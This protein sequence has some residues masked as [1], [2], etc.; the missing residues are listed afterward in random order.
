MIKETL[1]NIL[2]ELLF[3]IILDFIPKESLNIRLNLHH[4]TKQIRRWEAP[5]SRSHWLYAADFCFSLKY[6][7][8]VH[9]SYWDIKYIAQNSHFHGVPV[10]AF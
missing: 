1:Q 5:S 7:F 6:F 9:V 3:N 2:L 8:L 10:S 4:L